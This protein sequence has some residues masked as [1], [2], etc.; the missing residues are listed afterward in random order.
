M[1]IEFKKSNSPEDIQK[2]LEIRNKIFVQGQKVPLDE[3]VDGKDKDCDHYLLLMDNTAIG[4]ARVRYLD[5]AAMIERVAIMEEYQGMG[6]GKKIMNK[7]LA[8]LVLNPHILK[9]KLSSQS[10]AIP[11]YEKLGFIVCSEEYLDA[12]ILHKDMYYDLK[13]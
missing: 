1:N 4:V 13:R 12:D 10:Y 9:A 2:C 5:Q 8:D 3:E 6:L 7:I 11:F